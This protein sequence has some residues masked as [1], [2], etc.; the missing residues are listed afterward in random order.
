VRAD[1]QSRA[2]FP[3]VAPALE[4]LGQLEVALLELRKMQAEGQAR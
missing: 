3:V 1:E 2:P 4:L